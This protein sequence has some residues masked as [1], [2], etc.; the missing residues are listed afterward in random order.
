MQVWLP[1]VRAGTGVDVFTRRL[2]CALRAHGIDSRITWFPAWHEFLPEL[3]RLHPVP[4]GTDVIHANG[5][6]ASPLVGRDTPVLATIHH[7]VHDPAYAPYRSVAQGLYH[8]W[9]IQARELRAIR[10]ADAVS[11]VSAYVARTVEAFSERRPIHVVPNWIDT[12]LYAPDDTH[13]RNRARP[14]RLLLVG[15]QSRRKGF[16]LIPAFLS[17]LGPG[18][19]LRC[20]GGLR[21]A[22][23]ASMP[24]AVALG[25]IPERELVRE[26]QHC[27]AVV[28]LSRYEGFGY[29]ALEGMA[30]AKPF[31]GFTAGGFSEAVVHGVTGF[32]ESIDDVEALA[33]RC[34]L[35]AAA[36]A[37]VTSMGL[38]GRERA[39]GLFGVDTA[40]EAY[41]ELYN[42]IA[43]RSY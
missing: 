37:L 24:G 15:N 43:S 2:D 8:R 40:V 32:L 33:E 18:F 23:V 30:C 13:A 22:R 21:G 39:V 38:A 31:V 12:D 28:S 5:W 3:M 4:P 20:T 25:S 10:G 6:L 19:E 9:H 7:L 26:Y 11:C 16:D 34:H 41:V 14:F 1:A 27:D 29:S 17:R 35:L 42:Q 36:P